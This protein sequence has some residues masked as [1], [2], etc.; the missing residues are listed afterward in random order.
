MPSS[1]QG[2]LGQRAIAI[3]IVI[4]PLGLAGWALDQHISQLGAQISARSSIL[5][6]IALLVLTSFTY[7]AFKTV[8]LLDKDKF[9]TFWNNVIGLVLC[10]LGYLACIIVLALLPKNLG[11]FDAIVAVTAF[12]ATLGFCYSA[13]RFFLASVQSAL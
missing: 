2:K 6:F 5:L 1:G 3:A 10:F 12:I 9:T 7:D 4:A 11:Y 8:L 13:I